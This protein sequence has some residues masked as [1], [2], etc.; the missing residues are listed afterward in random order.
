MS[1]ITKIYAILLI[2]F[3]KQ[4]VVF[5]AFFRARSDINRLHLKH[6]MSHFSEEGK[7]LLGISCSA[8]RLIG[9]HIG[10]VVD[11]IKL[12]R[13]CVELAANL[14]LKLGRKPHKAFY[15]AL[16]LYEFL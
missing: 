8:R 4:P 6:G 3:T 14:L 15:T 11:I 13:R 2:D 16:R 10:K 1:K 5:S 9:N 12:L 7:K